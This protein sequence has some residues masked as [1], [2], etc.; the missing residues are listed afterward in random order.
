MQ[1]E[2]LHDTH[3]VQGAWQYIPG[4][5]LLHALPAVDVAAAVVVAVAVVFVLA[6]TSRRKSSLWR[7]DRFQ[8]TLGQKNYLE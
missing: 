2:D 1:V 6:L 4:T 5:L 7:R 3:A 8:N